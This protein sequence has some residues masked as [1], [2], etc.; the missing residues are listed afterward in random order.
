M[1]VVHVNTER[2]WRGGEQQVLYLA[3]GLREAGVQQTFVCQPTGELA[4]RLT[5]EG[6]EVLGRRMGGYADLRSSWFVARHARRVGADLLHLHTAN[7]HAI[8]TRAARWAG[9]PRPRTV[10]ARRVAYSIFRHSFLGLNRIKYTRTVDRILCITEAVRRQLLEDGLPAERLVVVPSGVD[11]ERFEAVEDKAQAFRT[12]LGIPADAWVVGA[13]GA[14]TPEKG[15]ETLVRAAAP[16]RDAI[17]TLRVVLVGEGPLRPAIEE[18]VAALDLGDRVHLAGFRDDVPA[19]LRWFD[20]L[21]FPSLM[22]GMGT[23][24]LDALCLATPVVAS[25][26][27]G[28]PEIIRDGEEGLLVEPGDPEALAAA[29]ARLHDDP[30]L[31]I[32]LGRRG[33][34]RVLASYTWKHTVRA[35]LAAYRAILDKGS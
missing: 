15:H 5:G 8:G 19:W 18:L 12:A 1:K 6:F 27:G 4:K 17:P 7:A 2:G 25:R 35:T 16:L 28:I 13:V 31:G 24:V 30:A 14:L 11:P 21:A 29:L 34:E 23:T 3:R 22:E 10:I 33:R 20:C 32:Q 26:V 9:R